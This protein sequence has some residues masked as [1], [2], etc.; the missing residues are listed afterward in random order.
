IVPQPG[1]NYV[2]ISDEFYRRLDQIK[3]EVPQDVK[4]NIALD[5][6]KF[7]KRSISEVEETLIIAIVLVILIIFLFFRDWLIAILQLIDLAVCLICAFFIMYVIESSRNVL[8][9]HD[10]VLVTSLVVYDGIM[11]TEN[12]FSMVERGMMNWQ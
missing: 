4:L 2:S 3:S 5:Q 8:S 10:I 12:I 6:T 1:S 9:L 11:V 7:I